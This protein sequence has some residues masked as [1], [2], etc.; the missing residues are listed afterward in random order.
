MPKPLPHSL[1][2]RELKQEDIPS[3]LDLLASAPDDGTLYRYP[4]YATYSQDMRGA[5]ARWLWHSVYDC[6]TLTRVAVIPSEK[7]QSTKAIGFSSWIR[8]IPSSDDPEKFQPKQWKRTTWMDRLNITL[9]KIEAKYSKFYSS[10][11]PFSNLTTQESTMRQSALN[12]ARSR[13]QSPSSKRS[14][15]VL[16]GLAIHSDY[17]GCGIGS[18]LVRWG[19]DR[20]MEERVA[21]F[22]GGEERGVKF[23][24]SALR[25][26]RIAETEYWLDRN[27][28]EINREEVIGGNGQWTRENGG[29]SGSEVVW[30]PHGIGANLAK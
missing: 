30:Y 6:N 7:G 22:T 8:M 11:H 1:S 15:Y 4:G 17:Q 19:M 18:L 27:G 14:C 26:E 10:I 29:V 3:L 20:A 16:S 5:S 13:V 28:R 21:V 9:M 25:F 12:K 23:Y 2:I 24:E